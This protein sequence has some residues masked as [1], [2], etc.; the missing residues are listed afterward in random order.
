MLYNSLYITNSIIASKHNHCL[1]FHPIE[2]PTVQVETFYLKGKMDLSLD[3][4][5]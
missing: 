3:Y 1:T 5:C 4:F 2:I